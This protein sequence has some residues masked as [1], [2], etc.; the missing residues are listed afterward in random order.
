[1]S[2][3]GS[4]ILAGASGQGG[5]GFAIERSLRFNSGDSAYLSRNFAAGN[6]KKWTWSGWFKLSKL[7]QRNYIFTNW[8]SS[9]QLSLYLEWT[10]SNKIRIGE[11]SSSAWEWQLDSTRQF[12]DP[13]AWYHL[14]V[15]VDTTQSTASDR[16]KVYINGEQLTSFSPS[17]YPSQNKDTYVNQAVEH[18]IGRLQ[19]TEAD[20]YLADV[21]FID[22]QALAPTDFGETDDNGVWQPKAYAGTYGTSVDQSQTWSNNITGG[23]GAY[24]AAANAFNGSLSDF[25]S[26]EYSS[27]MTY[28]NPSA[29]DTVISTFEIYGR[30][31]STSI[32]LE[33]NDTDIKSQLSTT[34]QWHTITGFTGQNFSKLYWRPTSGNSEVRIYAIRINGKILV[35][36]GISL[37]N[38]GFHLDFKDNSSNAALGTDTSGNSNTWTVN[39]ISATAPGL[40]TANQGMDVVTYTGNSSARTFSDFSF[41]PDFVWIKSRS[42]AAGHIITDSVRGVNNV[43]RSDS[44]AAEEGSPIYG[45]L[46]GFSS[47]G[48]T[49]SSGTHGSHGYGDV[50]MS[51]RTYVAW[52]WKAGG[53]ASS[54]TDGT[55]TSQVSAS[56]DYGFSIV[57]WTGAGSGNSS[58][59]HGLSTAP[60]WII[61]KNR[62]ATSNWSVY[63]SSVGNTKR[64]LLNSSAA[65]AAGSTFWNNTSPTSSVFSVGGDLNDSATKIA[66][67][68]SEVVGFSKF[69]SFTSATNGT[70]V[71]C[72]FKPRFIL[73]KSTGTGS[74]AIHDAARN[75]FGSYLLPDT[76]GAE[77]NNSDFTV[78]DTGFTFDNNS[79]GTTF[80]FAAFAAKPDG[81]VIDSLVDTPSQTA[82]PTDTGVGN[83]V[84]GN[85]ATLNPLDRQSTNGTLSNGNL[86]LTQSSAAWAMYRGTMA[87]S[88]GK[89]YYEV[90]IGASQYS[91]FGIL[92][93][94][95]QMA[96]ATNNWP[97]QTG[98]GNTYALYPYDGKK[99]DG[100]Q[101]ISYATANTSPAGDVYGVA[102]DLD[103]GT[104]TFYKNGSS[105]GQAFT[106]ISGTFAPAA[107][108][109]NQTASD[110]Y[111]FG[112][113]AFAYTAPS[114]YKALCTS[115]LPEPTIADGSLYFDTKLYTGNGSTQSVTGY[116]FSPDFVWLKSRNQTYNH[117]LLD[118]IRGAGKVLHS[119]NTDATQNQSDTLTSFNSD[120]FSLDSRTGVNSNNNTFVGWA[121]D[122]G[123]SNTTIAAGGLNSSVYDQS[124]TWS[125]IATLSG[126]GVNSSHPLTQ[127]FNGNLSN[128]VEGNTNGEYL[129]L[130]IST[131]IVS[132]GVR[133]YAAVGSTTPMVINLYN[134]SSNVHTTTSSTTGG[135]WHTTTYAGPITKIRIQRT[136]RPF[137]FDAV[138]VNGKILIDSGVSVTNVPS[139][140]STVRANS[141]AGFSIAA[142]SMPA[143][144]NP[145]IAHGLNAN[146]DMLIFKSRTSTEAWYI[147]HKGLTNQSNRFLRFDTSAELTNN[148]WFNNTAP[149]S[150]VVTLRVGGGI[151]ANE[152]VIIYS[153]SAVEGYSAMGSYT[154]NGSAD[155]P[156]IYTGFRP[157]WIMTKETTQAYPWQIQD[158]TR[159]PKNDAKEIL[160]A[161]NNWAE[162]N[163]N[164]NMDILSNGF[165][166][167]RGSAYFNL[168]GGTIIYVAFAENPFKTA[169]AR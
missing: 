159:A 140:A 71:S 107:W 134:G 67:C 20:F 26:P 55:I 84:V 32:T 47:N 162:A 133:V 16:V 49:L 91:A 86:D 8:N 61:L 4:N 150:S 59:G 164:A 137:E 77:G 3:V 5:A 101:G 111:N 160:Y 100:T 152:N 82:T 11:Y 141:S 155:G 151:S 93:I 136:G 165:K 50:N 56:T 138:E 31:Y 38:N 96:S 35:D 135:R 79:N 168:N 44:T 83:E 68:W 62:S 89:W 113:R 95:Y 94:E 39:N 72:G 24:G 17:N 54:N 127:G 114:G 40:T 110:S 76:N 14:V 148:N 147:T 119:N 167:R 102:F 166:P 105:L 117:Y 98:A 143:S 13:S 53:A 156:F 85:Y 75:N 157:A 81:S 112:Q 41:Q 122:A 78:S 52:C 43:L 80:I 87:V 145:T 125:N 118:Q 88:S 108:L 129:E 123:S 106:G 9:G 60:S 36:S 120:G 51:G 121:W 63:H 28:T 27:P 99:Y 18:N 128:R 115:N 90:N 149:T 7:D 57:S 29:S 64:L 10:N 132:G 22:G 25:A 169:R 109:Y 92:S 45:Y 2:F 142:A 163:S 21:H 154:G 15:A 33:L 74:W 130:P 153:F 23:S 66:Y 144:G 58:I 124:Q 42:D 146:P 65:E 104:I 73:I 37:S 116:N 158:T 19:T 139:I 34:V 97:S 12:R 6:R 30:Q 46:S 69:G 126:G 1:M 48:F 70:T 131:T 161:D 103:N